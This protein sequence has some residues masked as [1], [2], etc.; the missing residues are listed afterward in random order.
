MIYVKI[1][2]SQLT[3]SSIS[4]ADIID[5]MFID[6]AINSVGILIFLFIFWK[7]L[8]EDYTSNQ[9]FSIA[10]IIII[11][12]FLA[13]LTAKYLL[14]DL[15]FW[16]SLVGIAIG[17][18]VGIY[19]YGL[20]VY[21]SIDAAVISLLP[22][23]GLY[24]LADSIK[25]SNLTSLVGSLI[26]LGLMLLYFFFEAHYKN[27]SWYKSGRVGF[28]GLIVLA[29]FFLI[30]ATIAARFMTMISFSSE[31]EAIL[32]GVAAF[33]SLLIVFNLARQKT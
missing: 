10:L 11:S 25:N 7:K 27:F 30:R 33:A 28:S 31:Y 8:K 32:S 18:I 26:V 13:N 4:Y 16:L 20:K 12:I 29:I 14:S 23:F 21:E 17:L 24:L 6:I 5:N 3:F 9:I 1:C 19:R 15:W 2:Q 22:W